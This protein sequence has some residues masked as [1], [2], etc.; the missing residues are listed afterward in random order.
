MIAGSIEH[1]QSALIQT[2]V[3]LGHWLDDDRMLSGV[4]TGT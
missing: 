2:G 1:F 4:D 3:R